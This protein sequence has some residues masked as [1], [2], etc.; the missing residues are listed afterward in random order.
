MKIG[1]LLPRSDMFPSL[2]LDFL[3]GLKLVFDN[4]NKC[5]ELPKLIIEGIGNAT[6][7]SV[8]RISE[9]MILQEN[10]DL[11]IAFCGILKLEELVKI[12]D[13]Y[14]KPLIRA[15]LGGN[16]LTKKHFSK[17]VI[18]YSL[19]LW[20]SC[21]KAGVYAANQF[22]KK[23]ALA[24]SFYDGGY[25]L[26]ESFVD[27][28]TENGG[29]IVFNYVSPMEYKN[30]NFE[31]LITGIENSKPDVIFSVFSFKEGV[32][33]LNAFSQSKIND[34]IPIVTI[35]LMADES[36][37]TKEYQLPNVFSIASWAF[38]DSSIEMKNFISSYKKKYDQTPNI[39]SLLGFEV[40]ASIS[41]CLN[42]NKTIPV[43]IG[44]YF[45]NKNLTSPR[46]KLVFNNFNEINVTEFK[47][48]KF[49]FNNTNYQNTVIG[50]I[51]GSI[52]KNNHLKNEEILFSGWQ[53]PY[54]C[55]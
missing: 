13:S 27:G 5:Y 2:A 55:T 35:P 14:N 34:K 36:I 18:H 21:Y 30:E 41:Y 15:D 39:I 50:T 28:F 29:S 22:G 42:H 17:N 49:E 45:K 20:E 19:N 53:N 43:K 1:L 46:G 54:I 33:V 12:Y 23:A 52:S 16:F 11:T 47:L 6:D 31:N 25:Q 44:E 51:E 4:S 48:R 38:K 3:N 8:I 32:K 26:V 7:D 24:I 37:N 40:G 10:V 9:K